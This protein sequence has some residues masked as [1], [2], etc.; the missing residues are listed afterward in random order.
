MNQIELHNKIDEL[1]AKNSANAKTEK[2]SKL[3]SENE[4]A[5][6][7]FFSKADDQWLNW[8]WQNRFLDAIK[9]KAEDPTRYGYRTP[10]LGYLGRMAEKDPET[11]LDIM[12]KVQISADTFNPEVV[13]RFLWICGNLPADQLARIVK[14]IRDERWIPL[15][16]VFNQFGWEHEKIFATLAATQDYRS[17]LIL[18]EAVL[19][20]P[21]RE[22]IEKSPGPDIRDNLFY[23]NDLSHTKVFEHLVGVS[24]EYAEEVFALTVSVMGQVIRLR[25]E[26]KQDE[27]FDIY[28]RWILSDVDFFDLKPKQEKRFSSENDVRELAA[29][30]T[31]LARHLIGERDKETTH[32]QRIYQQ[33]IGSLPQS[34][35]M[36]RLR[37]FVLSLSPEV[38]KDDLKNSFFRLFEVKHYY[39]VMSGTEYFKALK[40]GFSVLSENDK[41]DYVKRTIEYFTQKNPEEE[42]YIHYGA[43]ILSTIASQLTEEETLRAGE[44]GFQLKQIFHPKPSLG[45]GRVGTVAPR[46]PITQE[47]FGKLSITA[48][49]GKLRNEWTKEKLAE[50]NT[51]VTH[52]DSLSPI[53][54]EGVGRYLTND[55]PNRLQEYIENADKF[56]EREVLDQHYT[57]S[58]LCGI[59][60]MIKKER[61]SAS[62]IDWDGVIQIC[63]AMKESGEKKPFEQTARERDS[64]FMWLAG[65]DAVH[66]AMANV[67]Q[68]LLTDKNG[69]LLFDFQEY[70]NKLF[71]IISYLLS[72]PDPSPEDEEIGTAKSTTKDSSNTEAIVSDPFAI[73][74]NTVRGRAFEAFVLFVYQD[75]KKFKE[76]D[77]GK[78][79]ND[80]KELYESVLKKEN[81]RALKFMFGYTLPTFYFRDKEW[82]QGL[83]PQIFPHE[84]AKKLLYVAAWEGYLARDLYEEMFFDPEIQKLYKRGLPLTDSEYPKQKHFRKPNEGLAVHLAL[85]FM[86]YKEFTFGHPSLDEFSKKNDPKQLARFIDFLGHSFIFGH[87]ENAYK[88]LKKDPWRKKR[89]MDFWDWM[90]CYHKN[91]E[92]FFEF[93]FWIKLEDGIFDPVWLAGRVKKTLKKT[94]GHL[95]RGGHRL[96]KSIVCLAEEAPMDTL[97]IVRWHLL[98]GGVRG[99][100]FQ[101]VA[102]LDNEWHGA[103]KI[104]HNNSKTRSGTDA[105]IS[106][107]IREGGSIFWN[108]K[109]IVNDES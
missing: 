64:F 33:H 31:T 21:T 73:A 39:D 9:Q 11:V 13:D 24:D 57:Y 65:W 7:Y 27:V 8:L 67:M 54:T 82:I 12:L 87:N 99:G 43:Q 78:I 55:L 29:V 103:L 23:F 10:E 48:I 63:T 101:S 45:Q 97:E 4:D 80:V 5:R 6:Q 92:P 32:A 107:L 74:I 22:E 40:E 2:A 20:V 94:K 53:N 60:E 95:K 100:K 89:L 19:T 49:A 109:K 93:G 83:L 76:E 79:S 86:H 25:G 38:F 14:K 37:L 17:L 66:S 102:Y 62:R 44:A 36:W 81:T 28:D 58:F 34:R 61:E 30:I 106:D 104:L 108:L 46:G 15:M 26:D 41:R 42:A 91:S 16:G 84:Q 35:A 47:E 50:Q 69:S 98:E 90:L 96:K 105:L 52:D 51:H 72:H 59:Q 75:G 77:T 56:F 88:L 70:R 68:E 1:L 85:A 18:A 3:I 71:G